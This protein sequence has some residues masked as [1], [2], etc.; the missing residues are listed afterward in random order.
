MQ[1]PE[2]KRPPRRPLDRDPAPPPRRALDV[3]GRS[4]SR[5]GHRGQRGRG[6]AA[7]DGL[8]RSTAHGLE[9]GR[10]RRG[11]R[12]ARGGRPASRVAGGA[13][14]GG[15]PH[16]GPEVRSAAGSDRGGIGP[17]CRGAGRLDAAAADPR[18]VRRPRRPRRRS[19]PR[20]LPRGPT[21]G[22]TRTTGATPTT[23]VTRRASRTRARRW[24]PTACRAAVADSRWRSSGPSPTARPPSSWAIGA[25]S[26][27]CST[28]GC[29]S[30][31]WLDPVVTTG[32]TLDGV[33][34][35]YDQPDTDPEALGDLTGPLDGVI[36]P[37]AGHGTFIAGIVHQACPD[38]DILAWRVVPSAGP[39]VESDW[40]AALA[41]ISEL[42][43]RFRA[44]ES[45]QPIDVLSLSMGYYHETPEDAL[46]DPTLYEILED[47]SRNGTLVVCSVGNDATARPNFPA[48]FAPVGGRRRASP[49]RSVV[50][51][52][53][54]GRRPEPERPHGRDVQQRRTVGAGLRPRSCSGEHLPDHLPGRTSVVGAIQGVRPGSRHHRPR[55][56]P[57]WVRGVERH[58]V[59]R[60]AARGPAGSSDR[61]G[62]RRR[63]R[64]RGRDRPSLGSGRGIDADQTMMSGC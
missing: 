44:G 58:V 9:V 64:D 52:D 53:R 29:G 51:S 18:A 55:R 7:S 54:L 36:D 45:D 46:F 10:L 61:P 43:R 13:G 27:R 25:R 47:I 15:P 30:H 16:G 21:T 12:G 1:Q 23:G 42:V 60:T 49:A 8:C 6:R 19:R 41:Q 4:G 48:A 20:H 40:I 57:G 31:P 28:P 5:S 17:S 14:G 38:A 37:M 50:A 11:R 22:A 32:V 35:G 33:A 34:I 26:S 39:I 62:P 2:Q 24:R 3:G 56:L 63:R 59:L